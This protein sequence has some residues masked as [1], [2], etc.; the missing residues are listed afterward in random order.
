[1]STTAYLIG[2]PKDGDRMVVQGQPREILVPLFTPDRY[3]SYD[4]SESYA[5]PTT[6]PTFKAGRYELTSRCRHRRDAAV[7][8]WVSSW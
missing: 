6:A 1:M 7:Y 5:V 2:G 8:E 3:R 4:Y